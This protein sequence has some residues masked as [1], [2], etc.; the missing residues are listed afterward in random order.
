MV[1]NVMERTIDCFFLFLFF[2]IFSGIPLELGET[3]AN[4]MY[5]V[6]RGLKFVEADPRVRSE[7]IIC[8][9]IGALH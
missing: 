8:D 7:M 6:W 5:D 3:T 2:F 1:A 4:A 9:I